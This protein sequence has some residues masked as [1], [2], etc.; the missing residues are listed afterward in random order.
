MAGGKETVMKTLLLDS[1]IEKIRSLPTLPSVVMTLNERLA[2]E[3]SSSENV[4]EIIEN[5]QSLASQVLRLA[6]S[7]FF[8]FKNRIVDIKQAISLIG[9]TT[10][11]NLVL[12]TSTLRHLSGFDGSEL[13]QPSLFWKHSVAVAVAAKIIVEQAKLKLESQAFTAGLLHDIGKVILYQWFANQFHEALQ[14]QMSHSMLL[15][16]AEREV[17]GQ[18][19][20]EVGYLL[21]QHWRFPLN[22]LQGIR[23][24][25]APCC[26]QEHA[27]ITAS[28][29]L[30]DIIIQGVDLGSDG[31]I[32]LSSIS[33][34]AWHLLKMSPRIVDQI[35]SEIF[36]STEHT[37]ELLGMSSS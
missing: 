36:D 20:A 21:G 5:D 16:D 28:V 18:T 35:M 37:L 1:I 31:E 32:F 12:A 17:L 9:F 6:N 8:G 15:I 34:D 19:H 33:D 11:G 23:Y 22:L 7:S 27:E 3:R 4:A 29:H 13:F 30:A 2:N 14:L 10:I 26:N 24:H 25:H